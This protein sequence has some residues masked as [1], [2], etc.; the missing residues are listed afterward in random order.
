MIPQGQLLLVSNTPRLSACS[1]AKLSQLM[2][3]SLEAPSALPQLGSGCDCVWCGTRSRLHHRGSVAPLCLAARYGSS[4][5][6]SAAAQIMGLGS[7]PG[8]GAKGSSEFTSAPTDGR[9]A[10]RGGLPEGYLSAASVFR[11]TVKPARPWISHSG[12][13]ALGFALCICIVWE[14]TACDVR[15]AAWAGRSLREC[16]KRPE[17]RCWT[18]VDIDMWTTGAGGIAIHSRSLSKKAVR[19]TILL[20]FK[21]ITSV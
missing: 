20:G 1:Q 10:R 9:R 8:Q 15:G 19:A 13:D 17:S 11:A 18:G 2:L 5:L 16:R 21:G 3:Q 14:K 12:S 7:C 6:L 4:A